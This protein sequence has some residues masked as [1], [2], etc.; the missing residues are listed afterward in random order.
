M[1]CHD[2]ATIEAKLTPAGAPL[3]KHEFAIEVDGVAQTC[4]VDFT[5]ATQIAYATCSAPDTSLWLGP[6][7]RGIDKQVD[8]DGGKNPG[9]VMHTEEPVA[10]QFMWQLSLGGSPGKAHVVQSHDGKPLLDQTAEFSSYTDYRPN[11]E[12]CEPVC[13]VAKVEW[14]GL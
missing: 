2:S 6:V 8:I 4:T 1:A 10:G 11:G 14:K 5:V 12:G 9:V 7:T 13:K 3:G